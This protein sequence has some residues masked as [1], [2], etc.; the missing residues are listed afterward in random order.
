M[1]HPASQS[2][3]AQTV[4]NAL[5][6][7]KSFETVRFAITGDACADLMSAIRACSDSSGLSARQVQLI[8]ECSAALYKEAAD[9]HDRVVLNQNQ[10]VVNPMYPQPPY[11]PP[12]SYTTASAF[13]AMGEEHKAA[14]LAQWESA[15]AMIQRDDDR[16]DRASGLSGLK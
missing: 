3:Q 13:N 2:G 4:A 15:K 5:S 7:E 11:G 16:P 10:R 12:G 9:Q 6:G 14:M 1:N 8:F